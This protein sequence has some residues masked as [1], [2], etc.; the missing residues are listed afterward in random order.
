[1]NPTLPLILRLYHPQKLYINI[2][3]MKTRTSLSH[4]TVMPGHHLPISNGVVA[5]AV[6]TF[7]FQVTP[8]PP[9]YLP[10]LQLPTPALASAA[11]TYFPTPST[12]PSSAL[13]FR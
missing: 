8:T 3:S 12:D 11:L 1:M 5:G 13:K 7:V 6:A 2:E 10:L 9:Q 4:L